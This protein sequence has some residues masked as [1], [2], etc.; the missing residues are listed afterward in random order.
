MNVSFSH[1]S[2]L[3]IESFLGGRPINEIEEHVNRIHPDILEMHQGKTQSK[4][5]GLTF[6]GHAIQSFIL[7]LS[8]YLAVRSCDKVSFSKEKRWIQE[9]ETNVRKYVSC[10]TLI[11]ML[12]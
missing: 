1:D 4:S 10:H 6:L 7:Y 8:R 9:I 5:T 3:T 12:G 2:L 11:S